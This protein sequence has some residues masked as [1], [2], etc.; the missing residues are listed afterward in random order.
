MREIYVNVGSGGFE[1]K[2]FGMG[3]QLVF[4]GQTLVG[5][6]IHHAD[7]AGFVFAK[8]YV[9]TVSRGV[10]AQIIHVAMEIDFLYQV[11]ILARVNPQFAFAAGDKKFFRVWSIGHTLRIGNAR[12]RV[13]AHAGADVDYLDGVVPERGDEQLVLAVE[14]EMIEAPLHAW[15]GNRL[16]QNQRARPIRSRRSLRLQ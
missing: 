4:F 1:M 9:Y 7:G 10:V 3:A 11:E 12:N 5:C 6:G 16:G 14:S 8:S 15:R 13:R 2:G